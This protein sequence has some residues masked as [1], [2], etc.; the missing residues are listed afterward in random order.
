MPACRPRT[1]ARPTPRHVHRRGPVARPGS[2]VRVVDGPGM[3]TRT[4][5]SIAP[6]KVC[7]MWGPRSRPWG[8]GCRRWMRRSRD[9]RSR[10]SSRAWSRL[11]VG[12]PT[13]AR[14]RGPGPGG[15]GTGPPVGTS[16]PRLA[17]YRRY[18]PAS[19]SRQ[20]A[21]RLAQVCGLRLAGRGPGPPVPVGPRPSGASR[22]GNPH[23]GARRRVI[24]RDDSSAPGA[25]PPA[26]G[27][28]GRTRGRQPCQPAQSGAGGDPSRA[29]G[30]RPTLWGSALERAPKHHPAAPWQGCCAHH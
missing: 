6:A 1:R 27:R 2:A 28:G 7:P 26:M 29:G 3:Q 17:T 18:P 30:H 9:H 4:P 12:G 5:W 24:C 20:R 25:R 16:R 22:G 13:A 11:A 19:R 10:R 15:A 23:P 14:P 21:A 8:H